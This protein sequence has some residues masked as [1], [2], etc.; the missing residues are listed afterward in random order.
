MEFNK[1]Q[2]DTANKNSNDN[3]NQK[4]FNNIDIVKLEPFEIKGNPNNTN[5]NQ[6]QNNINNI[7]QNVP[8][9]EEDEEE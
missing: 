8:S 2:N 3:N 4:E 7:P 5:V 9:G 6:N 1:L